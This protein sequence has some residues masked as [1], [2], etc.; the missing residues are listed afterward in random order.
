MGVEL[1]KKENLLYSFQKKAS[2]NTYE[3]QMFAEISLL[4]S[5]YIKYM[6]QY[7]AKYE[8]LSIKMTDVLQ[9]VKN[10]NVVDILTNYEFFDGF[11]TQIFGLFENQNFCKRT[12][13][14]ANVIFL[15]F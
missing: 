10:L 6:S 14:C 1:V 4:Y 3:S 5:N 11:I 15:L 12:R 8:L 13:I 2:D 7:K 9:K